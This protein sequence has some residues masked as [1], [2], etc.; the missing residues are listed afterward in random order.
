MRGLV[1]GLPSPHPVGLTLP[2]LFHEDNFAQRLTAALDEVLAPV[3]AVL[4]NVPAY[5]D[6]WL[7]PLDFVEFLAGWVGV[8]I[9]ET[10]PEDRQRAL[11]AGAVELYRWR[12]TARG[13]SSLVLL[14]T[15]VEPEIEETGGVSWSPTP[16]APFPGE[17]E[18]D[19]VVRVRVADPSV[20][21]VARLEAI[22]AQSK[23]AHVP[24]RVEVL[25]R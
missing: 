2:A 20:V 1:E 7:A 9:D 3:F 16:G 6:P 23:P 12:G 17:P 4:D 8:A 11:V 22:V 25:P 14:Y 10:W 19:L 18:P 24:H 21:D 13:L 15:G 5:L